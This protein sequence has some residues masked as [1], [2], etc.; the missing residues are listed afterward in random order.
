[1]ITKILIGLI[2]STWPFIIELFVIDGYRTI[3]LNRNDKHALTFSIWCVLVAA[4]C[5]A[6]PD[7][8]IETAVDPYG[9]G[10]RK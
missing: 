7:M 3:K 4:S 8:K 9:I 5:Y 2:L 1:M 10:I 6:N